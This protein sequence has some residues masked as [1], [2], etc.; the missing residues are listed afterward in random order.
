MAQTNATDFAK[1]VCAV[2]ALGGFAVLAQWAA[3]AQIVCA[4]LNCFFVPLLP[5]RNPHD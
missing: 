3:T 1:T 5:L 4:N 2:A